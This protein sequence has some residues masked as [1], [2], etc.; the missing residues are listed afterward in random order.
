LFDNSLVGYLILYTFGSLSIRQRVSLS[1]YPS[2]VFL[3]EILN[4]ITCKY[5]YEKD[6]VKPNIVVGSY[7]LKWDISSYGIAQNEVAELKGILSDLLP[8]ISS[9]IFDAAKEIHAVIKEKTARKARRIEELYSRA[10][11]YSQK[12]SCFIHF[13]D[14]TRWDPAY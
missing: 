2:I 9:A 10:P 7:Y 13:E 1:A 8:H 11:A 3:L 14:E 5:P 12:R 4:P 6:Y